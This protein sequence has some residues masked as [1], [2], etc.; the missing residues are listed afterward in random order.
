MS[1]E[2]PVDEL[3]PVGLAEKSLLLLNNLCN[4]R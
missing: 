1:T 3:S 2:I 4:R